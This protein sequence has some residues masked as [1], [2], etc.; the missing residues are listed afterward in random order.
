MLWPFRCTK[1]HNVLDPEGNTRSVVYDLAAYGVDLEEQCMIAS[2]ERNSCPHCVCKGEGLGNVECQ[3]PRSSEQ[4]MR[5]IKT[6]LTNFHS[7]FHRHLDPLEFL[8]R[9]KR[10][11][12]NGVHKPF[13]RSLPVLTWTKGLRGGA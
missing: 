4:I 10:F 9:S 12:L 8:K 5:D 3:C 6:V 7:V 2:I 13:W 11:G 1:P